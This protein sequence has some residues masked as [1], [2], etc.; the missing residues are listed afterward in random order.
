MALAGGEKANPKVLAQWGLPG[1]GKSTIYSRRKKG[2]G[3][4]M[5]LLQQLD[6]VKRKLDRLVHEADLNE[7]RWQSLLTRASFGDL[8]ED[9]PETGLGGVSSR[10]TWN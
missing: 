5:T 10:G 3:E 4:S 1:M 9:P 8:D 6:E 7:I 2:N